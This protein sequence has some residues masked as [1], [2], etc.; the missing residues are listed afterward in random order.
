[1][2][3]PACGTDK[4]ADITIRGGRI[5]SID[6]PGAS[7]GSADR[8][9]DA[10]GKIVCP[11][12]IDPH[13]HLREPG[14]E[15]KETIESGSRAAVA[16]GFTTVCCMPN[17]TPAMD[18][19]EIVRFIADRAEAEA[20]CRVFAVAAATRGRQGVEPTELRLLAKAGAVGF[21]DDGDVVASAGVMLRLMREIA[22]TG[23]CF[24]QHCQEP[25]LTRGASM[26]A[27]EV[28]T[29]LGLVG[30]PRVAE[31]LIIERDV[32]LVAESGCRYHVQHLS[33]GGS[34]EIIRRARRRPPRHRRGQPPPPAPDRSGVRR[35]QHAGQ[36][37]PP[38]ARAAG[39]RR[40]PRRHRRRHDH[41]ARDRP[42][43]AHHRREGPP[44][45][46][47]P[48]R[49]RRARDRAAAVRRGAGPLG[50]HR[51]APHAGD[52]DHRARTPLQPRPAAPRHGRPR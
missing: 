4:I 38:A 33:S 26:H 7:S 46:G 13:V 36:D 43:A 12:L 5:E 14:Q 6:A 9:I 45:R 39:H 8:V 3:D 48:V 37:E 19:P 2:I 50:R 27:G 51:L 47:C 42:R 23:L 34:V 15:H 40:D 30:W 16:G 32:R 41:R 10:T 22:P 11:G 28:S 52:A 24:M 44:L 1:M 17:T 18:S 20:S 29:R 21:S 25:T 31:E 49:H 35:I